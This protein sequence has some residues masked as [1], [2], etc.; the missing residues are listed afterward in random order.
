M[1]GLISVKDK[2][3]PNKP[4]LVQLENGKWVNLRPW[5][6]TE[7]RKATPFKK[8]STSII[9]PATQAEMQEI[10]TKNPGWKSRIG[11]LSPAQEKAAN[12]SLA[13]HKATNESLGSNRSTPAI[14]DVK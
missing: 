12:E 8:E 5:P 14:A 3:K 7:N 2:N 1:L 6:K 13:S 9:P 10:L 4:V 11:T